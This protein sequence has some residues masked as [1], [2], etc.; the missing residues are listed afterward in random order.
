MEADMK[1][2]RVGRFCLLAVLAVSAFAVSTAS[3]AEYEVKGLPEVGRCKKVAFGKGTYRG[4]A[5]IA[6]APPGRG[7]WE[8][9]QVNATDKAT[10]SGS[11]GEKTSATVGN[12]AIKSINDNFT[13]EHAEGKPARVAVK[14]EGCG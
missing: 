3:A 4:G 9:T 5:C 10:F 11:G 1:V 2:I 7:S 14:S 13:G 12:G 8:W 6:V